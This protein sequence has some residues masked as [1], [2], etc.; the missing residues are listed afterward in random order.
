MAAKNKDTKPS[1][2]DLVKATAAN[3]AESRA[4]LRHAIDVPLEGVTIETVDG[5]R[6]EVE[7]KKQLLDQAGVHALIKSLSQASQETY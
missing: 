1:D 7:V 2:V 5:A 4:G 3:P 6:A